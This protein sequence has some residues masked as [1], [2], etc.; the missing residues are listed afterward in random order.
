MKISQLIKV[1]IEN[2]E[3]QKN[4]LFFHGS[5]GIGK[6]EGVEQAAEFLGKKRKKFILRT[7]ILSQFESVDL[8]GLPS[9]ENSVTAWNPPADLTFDDDAEGIV[10]FDEMSNAAQDVQKAAQQ[11][12]H[13]RKL[14]E[15][16]IPKGIV[17]IAAGNRQTDKAGANRLLTALANRFEHHDIEVDSEDW[18]KWA[19]EKNLDHSV[20][21]F[22][23]WQPSML[24][25]FDSNRHINAT[26]RSWKKVSDLVGSS[27][28]DD[29]VLGTIGPGPGAMYLGF[30]KVWMDL[31]SAESIWKDPDAVEMPK[32]QDIQYATAMSLAL[33]AKPENFSNALKFMKKAGKDMQVVFI[34]F[35]CNANRLIRETADFRAYLKENKGVLFH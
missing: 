19:I 17:F 15:L 12:I 22:I 18:L 16:H 13:A 31:P 25:D 33:K 21:A 4:P 10:F 9:V 7:I 32:K 26:P 8:R 2:Y 23:H 29:R 35:S 11:I 6:T 5:P 28:F 34:K 30:N 24:N 20:I 3:Q 27:M 14:G 1:I